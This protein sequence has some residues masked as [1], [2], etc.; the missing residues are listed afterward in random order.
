MTSVLK[1]DVG[2]IYILLRVVFK[3]H[4]AFLY[5]R[6]KFVD[7]SYLLHCTANIP[8]HDRRCNSRSSLTASDCTST[9]GSPVKT[10]MVQCTAQASNSVKIP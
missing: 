2:P 7:I 3:L 8:A 5:A 4:E 6:F 10:E 9:S 1:S